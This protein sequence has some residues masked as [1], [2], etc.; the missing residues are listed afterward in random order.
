MSIGVGRFVMILAPT[1]DRLYVKDG[2]KTR[3]I[4]HEV[5]DSPEGIHL[6]ED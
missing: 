2:D 4:G 6:S 3:M 1:V 5:R